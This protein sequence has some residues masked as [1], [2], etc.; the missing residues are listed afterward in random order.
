LWEGTPLTAFEALAMGKPIVAT[1]AD[2]L[3]D[4]LT[5]GVDARIVPRRDAPA[6]ARAIVDLA[7]DP[8]ARAALS[9]NARLTGARYDI[10]VF[11]RKMERLYEVLHRSSRATR[12]SR[13]PTR[14]PGLSRRRRAAS[15]TSV[16]A[17]GD[18][19]PPVDRSAPWRRCSSASRSS[20][21][22]LG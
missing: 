15:V 18:R 17:R 22:A 6:L 8:Q 10:D 12:P 19:R 9:A 13:H 4:I 16:M 2:G 20:A 14:R 1:D 5:S 3:A 11:V 21:C 7:G